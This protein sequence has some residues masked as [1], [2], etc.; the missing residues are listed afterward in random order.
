MGEVWNPDYDHTEDHRW[1][2]SARA[3]TEVEVVEFDIKKFHSIC[4]KTQEF[5]TELCC[6]KRASR[7]YPSLMK[8]WEFFTGYLMILMNKI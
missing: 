7:P 2:V 4:S 6:Q 5:F 3:D 1:I 8:R